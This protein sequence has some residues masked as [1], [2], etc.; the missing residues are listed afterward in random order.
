MFPTLNEKCMMGVTSLEVYNTVYSITENNTKLQI[1]LKYE[2]L[3]TLEFDIGVVP[4]IK[5]LYET[6]DLENDKLYYEF[7]E[8][9]NIFSTTSY[10]ERRN[11]RKK[12][13]TI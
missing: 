3:D 7:I 1:L 2:Q 13:L 5:K 6:Y 10:K 4:N 9:A 11:F 12:I 8:K